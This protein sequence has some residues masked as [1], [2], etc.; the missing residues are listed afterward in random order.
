MENQLRTRTCFKG[1]QSFVKPSTLIAFVFVLP[2]AHAQG[3]GYWHTSGNKILDSNNKS[4]RISGTNWSGFETPSEVVHGLYAQDYKYILDGIKSNGYN[5]VRLPFSNQMVEY[6][7]VP[8][9]DYMAYGNASGPINTDL[10]GL[11]SL[12][13]LDRIVAYAGDI[14]LRIVLDNHRSDAG[15]TAE[16]NGLWYTPDYPEPDWIGDWEMLAERYKGNSAVI[17][18]DLRNE[19]HSVSGGG[20][21][22]DC[23]TE[24]NDW[25]LAAERGGNAILRVNP[26]LLIFV[27]GTDKKDNRQY[28]WGGN[29]E[30]VKDAPVVLDV[31][32]QLVY[33]AHEYGP[34]LYAQSWF[35]AKTTAESLDALRTE[36]WG[37]ISQDKIAPVWMG[38]FGT[39]NTAASLESGEPGSQGQWFQSLVAYLAKNENVSWTYWDM[40]E[41]N[42]ALLD[43]DWDST[44]VSPKKQEMLASLQFKL[45]GNP[46]ATTTPP[47]KL[48]A[49]AVSA[50]EIDLTW[51]DS[52]TPE[53]T[54]NV[55]SSSTANFEASSATLIASGL[56]SSAYQGTDL[57]SSTTYYY[58]VEALAAAGVST[59]SNQASAT[60]QAATQQRAACHVSYSIVNNWDTGF[61]ANLVIENTGT[62]NLASWT[63]AWTFPNNQAITDL[64][65]GVETQSGETVKVS[66]E[67]YNGTV[68]AGGSVQGIGL[69]ANYSGTNSMP[70]TFTLNGVVC[71]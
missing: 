42:Y 5:T 51:V 52:T 46:P 35:N 6:P 43:G 7:I 40:A 31:H 26:K 25:H 10:E 56:T 38:E 32:H 58:L 17:G 69:T 1:I 28:W 27:E 64:W 50:T 14:G 2:F 67:S 9:S 8:T 23:G 36:M 24:A 16:E 57:R 11:D 15:E 39:L 44:P 30:G 48:T 29:L 49:K 45:A 47:G 33:S 61:Q 34:V 53:A 12:Q 21:C 18:M 3:A 19:P 68:A 63:L 13:I 59:P 66:N 70:A 71:K 54:Y 60:T 20:A 65:N 41:D 55:Y 22:W 62:T 4:V 37:Y